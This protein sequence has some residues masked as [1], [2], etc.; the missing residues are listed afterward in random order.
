MYYHY[1]L[2]CTVCTYAMYTACVM[3]GKRHLILYIRK[4]GSLTKLLPLR[5][6]EI[7]RPMM[8]MMRSQRLTRTKRPDWMLIRK[9]LIL[10]GKSSG[11]ARDNESRTFPA[12][13]KHTHT[14]SCKITVPFDADLNPIHASILT[15]SGN[16]S[17]SAIFLPGFV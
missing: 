16:I 6:G 3:C 15:W 7:P 8:I 4:N 12:A 1:A 17:T 11:P 9:L 5:V 13:R 2:A 14:H 10:P